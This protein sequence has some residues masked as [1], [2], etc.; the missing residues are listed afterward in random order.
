MIF[1]T[2]ILEFYYDTMGQ[3]EQ[4]FHRLIHPLPT[5]LGHLARSLNMEKENG[6]QAQVELG[7]FVDVQHCSGFGMKEQTQSRT[8]RYLLA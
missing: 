7:L 8:V 4:K 1:E 6:G 2:R 5:D 3:P